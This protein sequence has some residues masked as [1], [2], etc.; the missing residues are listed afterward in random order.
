MRKSFH[1]KHFTLIELLVVIAIIAILAAMLLPALGKA[2]NKASSISCINNLKQASL[3]CLM[4]ADEYDQLVPTRDNN[5]FKG[6]ANWGHRLM[7]AGLVQAGGWKGFTCPKSS[8]P[9]DTKNSSRIGDF[10]YGINLGWV[11]Q[12]NGT[13]VTK[14]GANHPYMKGY[15]G[16]DEFGYWIVFK[17]QQPGKMI[18]LADTYVNSSGK[19]CTYHRIV[20]DKTTMNTTGYLRDFHASS[21]CNMSFWDGHV[22]SLNSNALDKFLPRTGSIL[23]GTH[24]AQYGTFAQ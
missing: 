17:I 10:S 1:A 19:N 14:P 7:A 12:L 15:K 3:T 8:F 9:S 20:L 16:N 23:A 2:R 22:A 21:Q 11:V 24:W 4:Y 6:A 13:N 18:M 5:L